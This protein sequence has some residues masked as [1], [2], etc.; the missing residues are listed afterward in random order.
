MKRIH[1]AVGVIIKDGKIFVTRRADH[2]HQGGKW[3]FPGGKVEYGETVEQALERELFEEVG[4]SALKTSPLIKVSHDYG[5]KQVLLE[6]LL[7][8]NFDK[9]PYGKEGQESLWLEKE[10]L[11][12]L[13]FPKANNVIIEKLLAIQI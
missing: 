1:V 7:V 11:K 13:D 12:E 6:T 5:D 2:L 4:I 10:K 9:E 8:T 3:E